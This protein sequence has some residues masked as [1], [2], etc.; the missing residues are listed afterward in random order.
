MNA[1]RWARLLL[2]VALLAPVLAVPTTQAQVGAER[3]ALAEV[4]LRI[5]QV[6]VLRGEFVQEKQLQGFARPLR[7]EGR[8]LL[9]NGRGLWWQT[10]RP[11]ASELVLTAERIRSHS[12]SSQ[13]ETDARTQPALRAIN[14]LMFALMRG[15]L[16][17]LTRQF[18][19]QPS[20]LDGGGWRLQLTP[21]GGAARALRQVRLD[22]DRYVRHLEIED[23]QGNLTRLAFSALSEVPAQLSSEEARRFD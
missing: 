19:L 18:S 16:Q 6:S 7:S 17:A 4:Q 3:A 10:Q 12:G 13:A 1:A 8:F 21:K 15:D 20:L 5:A 9:A 22:G 11:L 2:L 14:T 23:R